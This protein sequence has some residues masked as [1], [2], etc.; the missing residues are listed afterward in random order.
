MTARVTRL[1]AAL[2]LTA[3]GLIHYDLWNAGYRHIPRIGP[4]FMVN[5]VISIAIA[6]TLVVSRRAAVAVAG[7]VFAALSLAGLVLSRTIG[8]LGF[9]EMVWTPPAINTLA[10]EVGAIITLGVGLGLQL[11]THHRS[12]AATT[13]F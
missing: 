5:F 3:G 1:F 7:I 12:P 6:A 4:L 2:L 9:T 11:R 8:V 13:A 10:S